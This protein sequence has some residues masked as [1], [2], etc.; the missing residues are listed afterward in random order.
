MAH[1]VIPFTDQGSFTRESIT[2]IICPSGGHASN[3]EQLRFVQEGLKTEKDRLQLLL[4]LAAQFAPDMELWQFLRTASATIRRMT[5]CDLIAI[6]LPDQEHGLLRLFALDTWKDGDQMVCEGD[7]S[8]EAA[9]EVFRTK[10]LMHTREGTGYLIPLLRHSRTLGVL[11][12]NWRGKLLPLE[13]DFLKQI[14]GQVAIA[15]ANAFAYAEVRQL[16]EQLSREKLYL[17]DE[18]RSEQGFEDIIGR[19]SG[20][21]A[22]LRSIELVAPTDATVLI[23]GETGTGKELIARAIHERSP[24]SSKPFV[25][26]NC[27]AIPTGLL[28]SELF[29]HE[30][31]AF[32]GAIMSRMGRFELA[33]H[34]SAFL[35]EIGDI[36]LELQPKLLRVLQEREFERLGSARTIKTDAR[37]IAATN[38][39]LAACV[40]EG[41]FR[42]DLFYRLNIFPIRVPALRERREDIPLLVRHFAQQCARRMNRAIDTIPSETMEALVRH[43]WPGNIR[44]LQNVIERSVILSPGP[45]LH[46]P[47]AALGSHRVPDDAET[48]SKTLKETEREHI[49]SILK[50]TKWVVA[51][52]Q[53]A[54]ARLGM[55]RSTLQFQMKRLGIVRPWKE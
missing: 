37:L 6:H 10:R 31:G 9:C 55:K 32:T 49:I 16:K 35:D 51:G 12:F 1:A 20:I 42:A 38:R 48:T 24:R 22:V 44:E 33:N 28:E 45:V 52:P 15:I 27:A 7:N 36:A 23:H 46:V 29:G 43:P 3:F 17:E 39:N 13:I 5:Q 2:N 19:S 47:I 21:R 41:T 26:L 53:G 18:I 4:D 8:G 34:G 25:K 14:A 30:K 40:Q 50:Q 11:E 54:A